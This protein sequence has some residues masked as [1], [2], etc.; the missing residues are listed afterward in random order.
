MSTKSHQRPNSSSTF[1]DLIDSIREHLGTPLQLESNEI[2]HVYLQEIL[3]EYQSNEREWEQYALS[4]PSKSYSR[5]GVE[6]I[7]CNANLL[8]LVWQPGKSSFI[9]DHAKAHCVMKILKG[10]LIEKLYKVQPLEED[11][12]NLEC[13][14]ETILHKNQVAYIN[15]SIGLHKMVNADP[16]QIAVSLHLYTP[17][18]AN[19]HGCSFYEEKNGKKHHVL[20][21]KLYSWKGKKII[22]INDNCVG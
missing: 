15:D 4:D 16:D 14:K 7:S 6:N 1:Q 17:P 20:M 22:G 3:K 18:Y 21:S 8:I 19:L 5:N 2:D 13:F 9:H 11:E 12:N 10:S